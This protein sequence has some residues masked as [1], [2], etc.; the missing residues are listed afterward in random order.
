MV[1]GEVP[2]RLNIFLKIF[3]KD[4]LLKALLEEKINVSSWYSGLDLF[5]YKNLNLKN[6]DLHSKSILNLWIN[7]KCDKGYQK[8][9]IKIINKLLKFYLC[10]LFSQVLLQKYMIID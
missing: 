8:K 6:S 2:W 9:I 1:K 5:F 10:I 3:I 4:Y 7:N